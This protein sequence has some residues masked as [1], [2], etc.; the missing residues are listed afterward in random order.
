M[1]RP[2]TELCR[3]APR[4]LLLQITDEGLAVPDSRGPGVYWILS[5]GRQQ[6]GAQRSLSILNGFS[7][8][9]THGRSQNF[10]GIWLFPPF[11][12]LPFPLSFSLPFFFSFFLPFPLSFPFLRSRTA[13]IQLETSKL[14]SAGSWAYSPSRNQIWCILALKYGIW[15]QHFNCF[16]QNQLT[17]FSACNLDNKSKQKRR[18]KFKSG[19]TNNVRAKRAKIFL[20]CCAHNCHINFKIFLHFG[21]RGWIRYP[22]LIHIHCMSRE[23]QKEGQEVLIFRQTDS[24][25]CPIQ[26]IIGAQDF[27]FRRKFFQIKIL[28]SNF[29]FLDENFLQIKIEKETIAPLPCDDATGSTRHVVRNVTFH[30]PSDVL[31][32]IGTSS[33]WA[34]INQSDAELNNL[35]CGGRDE[36]FAASCLCPWVQRLALA[37]RLRYDAIV[38]CLTRQGW[39]GTEAPLGECNEKRLI[40][41]S[42]TAAA[43]RQGG[44]GSLV[45]ARPIPPSHYSATDVR[46]VICAAGFFVPVIVNVSFKTVVFD[47]GLTGLNHYAEPAGQYVVPSPSVTCTLE[48]A[49]FSWAFDDICTRSF[50]F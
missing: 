14:S 34:Y 29:V 18:N 4:T 30:D 41:L 17:K 25:K 20:K 19:G 13:Q 7:D 22:P 45:R 44:T 43:Q 5:S 2:K 21:G 6:S 8:A 1:P 28:A 40:T 35:S 39:A 31:C 3:P 37:G 26:D 10:W 23:F 27:N 38:N 49:S 33:N 15:W 11:F 47:L 16:P 36:D 46:S 24:C 12:C 50:T 32:R 42:C 9:L 48:H